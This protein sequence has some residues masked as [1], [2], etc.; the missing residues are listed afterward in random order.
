MYITYT[1]HLIFPQNS[2]VT[3]FERKGILE[4]S[5]GVL[6]KEWEAFR[7]IQL[8]LGLGYGFLLFLT[9]GQLLI[10]YFYNGPWH[11]LSR[12]VAKPKQCK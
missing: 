9:L 10:F 5:I 1:T 2:G 8:A 3:I 7:D 4:N 6:P 12:I 11:P